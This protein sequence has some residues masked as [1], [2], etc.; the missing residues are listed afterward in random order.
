MEITKIPSFLN[1][2][3]FLFLV[4]TLILIILHLRMPEK[5]LVW[6]KQNNENY[7][8]DWRITGLYINPNEL[9]YALVIHSFVFWFI[10]RIYL[11]LSII[12]LAFYPSLSFL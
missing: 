9:G 11:T 2:F 8:M 5:R 7:K 12:P 3:C 1:I 10:I 6:F 4:I